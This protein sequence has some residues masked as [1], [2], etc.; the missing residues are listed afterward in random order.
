[1]GVEDIPTFLYDIL[2]MEPKRQGVSAN[3]PFSIY[4]VEGQE[5]LLAYGT[6]GYIV[7]FYPY[8][9]K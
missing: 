9:E 2:A 1:M 8:G 5:Y 4:E 6:N 3:G 7:S